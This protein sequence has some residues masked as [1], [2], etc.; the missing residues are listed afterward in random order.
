MVADDGIWVSPHVIEELI[1][2]FLGIFSRSCLLCGNV[3]EGHEYSGVHCPYIVE[4]A[5]DD[6]LDSFLSS[7]VNQWTFICWTRSLIVLA[8]IDRIGREGTMLWFQ[9]GNVG[10]PCELL[11]YIFGHG[12]VNI[13]FL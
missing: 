12:E 10:V 2:L 1:D 9:R 13:L 4:E 6:L 7:F 3:R 8:V 5:A 11:R